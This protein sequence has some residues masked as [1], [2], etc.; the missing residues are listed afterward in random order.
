MMNSVDFFV[1]CFLFFQFFFSEESTKMD[2][3][4]ILVVFHF[5]IL[6]HFTKHNSTFIIP[7]H[8]YRKPVKQMILLNL[9]AK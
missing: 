9:F 6:L 3:K 8:L 2:L 4:R 7:C 1:S 5:F